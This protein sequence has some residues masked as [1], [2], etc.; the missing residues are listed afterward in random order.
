MKFGVTPLN[1]EFNKGKQ[2]PK[3]RRNPP[4]FVAAPKGFK[5]STPLDNLKGREFTWEPSGLQI[6]FMHE[7]AEI[8]YAGEK[9]GESGIKFEIPAS[10]KFLRD[11]A[12]AMLTKAD[13]LEKLDAERS[14]P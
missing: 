1:Q 6:E 8:H 4:I 13:E 10:P 12:K 3:P 2:M 5:A 9:A 7:T 11:F 14:G